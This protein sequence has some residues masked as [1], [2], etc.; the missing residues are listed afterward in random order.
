MTSDGDDQRAGREATQWL[1]ELRENPDDSGVRARFDAWLAA[2]AA[3]Q[4]AW[5]ETRRLLH[6]VTLTRRAAPLPY[7]SVADGHTVDLA[8]GFRRRRLRRLVVGGTMAAIAACLMLVFGPSMLL[9]LQASYMTSTAEIRS[10]RLDDGSIVQ[11]A[12]D[13]AIDIAF[14]P[15]ERRVRLLRGEA[16]FEVTHDAV[17]PFTVESGAVRTTVLGTSFDVRLASDATD[18]TVREGIVRVVDDNATPPVSERL[19]AGDHV[20]VGTGGRVVRTASSPEETAAWLRG[21]ILATDRTVA[22]VVDELRRYHRGTIIIADGALARERITGV[23]KL[24]DPPTA[25]RAV[26]SAHGASV[27]Q[28]T[29]WVIVLSRY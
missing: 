14:A 7:P 8:K 27:R 12:P 24:A 9:R 11:L 6:L 29:P 22:D 1:I 20:K 21:E 18:V 17:Q 3:N 2:S 28:I 23:Y 15:G 5:A 13:S 16:F 10:L 4:A 25:L 19:V 26:A